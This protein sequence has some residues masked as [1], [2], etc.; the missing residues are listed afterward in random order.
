MNEYAK[1]K[2][3]IFS[4]SS[5]ILFITEICQIYNPFWPR[6]RR[7]G[8]FIWTALIIASRLPLIVRM[9]IGYFPRHSPFQINFQPF[10]S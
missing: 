9:L 2:K 7:L 8:N 1:T 3:M 10:V 6:L 5:L 4:L